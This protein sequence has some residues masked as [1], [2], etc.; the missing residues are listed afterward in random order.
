MGEGDPRA[1]RDI[2]IPTQSETV[3]VG[4]IYPELGEEGQKGY[5]PSN[6]FDE[7]VFPR[8]AEALKNREWFGKLAQDVLD[9]KKSA[10]FVVMV[11]GIVIFAAAG[12]GYEFGIRKGKDIRHLVSGI[13][14]LRRKSSK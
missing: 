10:V 9:N 8:V 14:Q 7:K 6:V 1:R 11:S 13:N 2:I 12:A 4:G 5:R 3:T